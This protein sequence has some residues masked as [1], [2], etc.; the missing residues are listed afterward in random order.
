MKIPLC[1]FI[2]NTV[3]T[4]S[5]IEIPLCTLIQDCTIIRDTRVQKNVEMEVVH[6]FGS[7]PAFQ[8]LFWPWM[9]VKSERYAVAASET[10][11]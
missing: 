11:E 1:T 9:T 10:E 6:L 4:D 3:R 5:M 7:S 8:N 2:R